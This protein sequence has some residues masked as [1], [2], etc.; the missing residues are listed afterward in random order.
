MEML[1]E[2]CCEGWLEG[3]VLSGRHGIFACYEAFLTI[4]DSMVQQ[5]AKWQKMAREVS[6]RVPAAS[7]N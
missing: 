2:H 5:F 4:V 3:Y 6:W 7:L 1:S